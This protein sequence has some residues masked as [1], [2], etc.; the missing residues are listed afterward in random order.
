MAAGI[1]IR[2]ANRYWSRAVQILLAKHIGARWD[3]VDTIPWSTFRLWLVVKRG[4]NGRWYLMWTPERFFD[5]IDLPEWD[6]KTLIAA[7]PKEPA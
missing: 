3:V 1:K 6:A 4:V 2:C 5:E 7:A